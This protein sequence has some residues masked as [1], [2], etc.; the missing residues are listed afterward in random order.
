MLMKM[1]KSKCK[2]DSRHI[3]ICLHYKCVLY[4]ETNKPPKTKAIEKSKLTVNIYI[5]FPQC[6]N[7]IALEVI[8]KN[9]LSQFKQYSNAAKHHLLYFA[10][11][12][13]K[14]SKMQDLM[15]NHFPN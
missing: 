14:S 5:F 15:P 1:K 9:I 10:F 6:F 8:L 13:N 4:T 3:V 11:F 2:Y 7:F 12:N